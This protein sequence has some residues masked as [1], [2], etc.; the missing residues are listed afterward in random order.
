MLHA[1]FSW[2]SWSSARPKSRTAWQAP[3]RLPSLIKA[4]AQPSS[5]CCHGYAEVIFQIRF[6]K[7]IKLKA[8]QNWCSFSFFFFYFVSVVCVFVMG[9]AWGSVLVTCC[10]KPTLARH[11][12]VA[13]IPH[14]ESHLHAKLLYSCDGRQ[15]KSWSAKH[16]PHSSFP[17]FFTSAM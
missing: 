7:W 9:S 11:V 1:A 17:L 8:E 3:S 13:V 10:I 15:R 12:F 2:F 5:I 16:A 4:P 6:S 14:S